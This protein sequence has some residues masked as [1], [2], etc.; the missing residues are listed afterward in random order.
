MEPVGELYSSDKVKDE[1]SKGTIC[2]LSGGTGNPFFTTDTAAAL[3]AVETGAEILLKGTRVDGVYTDD[4]EKNPNAVRFDT[5]TFAEAIERQL[6]VMDST[7]F[8]MC[9]ENNMPVIVFDMNKRGNLKKVVGGI[10]TG[11]I[12][13]N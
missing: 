1:L 12:V 11:T 4:P 3:R 8:T 9:R 13:S 5:L 7:A 2:I 10:K 6:K